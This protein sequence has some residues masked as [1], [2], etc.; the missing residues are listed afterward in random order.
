METSE[1]AIAFAS[2]AANLDPAVLAIVQTVAEDV[3]RQVLAT[4]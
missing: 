3:A 2:E 4:A 1:D